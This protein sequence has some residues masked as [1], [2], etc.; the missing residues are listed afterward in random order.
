MRSTPN[1]EYLPE[2]LLSHV[3]NQLFWRVH[4]TP[5]ILRY[6]TARYATGTSHL[7]ELPIGARFIG[8][9]E[10]QI[11]DALHVVITIQRERGHALPFAVNGYIA[12][13][14]RRNCVLGSRETQILTYT[15][16]LAGRMSLELLQ[17]PV[18]NSYDLVVGVE[19]SPLDA[20]IMN[21]INRSDLD[22]SSNAQEGMLNL[23][24]VCVNRLC[25]QCDDRF[26]DRLQK[27]AFIEMLLQRHA[28]RF[29]GSVS[30]QETIGYIAE[31]IKQNF[32]AQ[33][34]AQGLDPDDLDDFWAADRKRRNT[35]RPFNAKKTK[36]R[37]DL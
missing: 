15:I 37:L 33:M 8:P 25:E 9:G 17:N 4:D 35:P 30:T 13:E 12:R 7:I 27:R 22:A 10:E 34:S 20:V 16:L 1:F 24:R 21:F 2:H 32:A 23:F 6:A 3:A 28:T 26:G 11:T 31:T 19:G 14:F 5:L 29:H 36:R 18:D